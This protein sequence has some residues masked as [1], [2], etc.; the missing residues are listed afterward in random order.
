MQLLIVGQKRRITASFHL[1]PLARAR[2]RA[3]RDPVFPSRRRSG[4]SEAA[5]PDR[6]EQHIVC[7]ADVKIIA[8]QITRYRGLAKAERMVLR[9]E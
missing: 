4:L 8:R 6:A 2:L 5:G 3:S 7:Q 1:C 9:V